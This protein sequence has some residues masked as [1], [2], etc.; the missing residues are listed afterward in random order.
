MQVKRVAV[1][2]GSGKL[3]RTVI[4]DLIEHGYEVTCIDTRP[5]DVRNCTFIRATL[6]D[7][8]EAY[9][10]LKGTDALIHL[11]AIPSLSGFT[12]SHIYFN[13]VMSTYYML[14]AAEALGMRRVVI[15]SSESA[16]GF[17]W[18]PRQFVPD[19]FPVDE[20]HPAKPQETYGLSKILNEGTAAMFYR[21]SAMQVV[22]M[23][24][25]TIISE[26]DWPNVIKV[27]ER[28]P[29][30]YKRNLYSHVDAR[31]AAAACRLALELDVDVPQ[32]LNITNNVTMSDIPTMELLERYFPEVEVRGDLPGHTS[33]VSNRLAKEALGWDPVYQWRNYS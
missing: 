14:E 15:G 19:Y 10:V 4:R 8:G 18:A 29:T 32:P 33:L 12:H 26:E 13:N 30:H 16:Y 20:Q 27:M 24:F 11:A 22:P 25:S 5:P 3:G 17:F 6:T 1:T 2:G 28:D 7:A 9:G 31:D 21:H 23:R